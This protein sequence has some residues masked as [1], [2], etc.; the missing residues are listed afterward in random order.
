MPTSRLP[1]RDLN[2]AWI[3]KTAQADETC[4]LAGVAG[5]HAGPLT[6]AGP[7]ALPGNPLEVQV[8]N[9]ADDPG[10]NPE[11]RLAFTVS[12]L[13]SSCKEDRLATCIMLW[14]ACSAGRKPVSVLTRTHLV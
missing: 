13:L 8:Y 12:L 6:T 10:I 11:N 9:G 7:K 5:F 2:S 3:R 14:H 4:V 1:P